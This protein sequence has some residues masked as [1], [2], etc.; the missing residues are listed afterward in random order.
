M[1]LLNGRMAKQWTVFEAV[2]MSP[3]APRIQRTEMRRAFYAGAEAL[4]REIMGSLD[5]EAE[6]TDADTVIMDQIVAEL[7]AFG[8]AVGRGEA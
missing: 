5:P 1:A 3:T 6:V 7:T 4:L 8:E 2:V